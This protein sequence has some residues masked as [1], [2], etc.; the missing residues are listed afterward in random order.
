LLSEE[1][2]PLHLPWGEENLKTHFSYKNSMLQG[3]LA[4]RENWLQLQGFWPSGFT[5]GGKLCQPDILSARS[6]RG[7][8]RQNPS[9]E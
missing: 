2:G 6:A 9:K 5:Y 7:S 4:G 1:A 3:M 8:R